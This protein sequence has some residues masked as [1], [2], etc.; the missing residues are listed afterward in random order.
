MSKLAIVLGELG[1]KT[2]YGAALS[3]A[4]L[5][6]EAT[7]FA[8]ANSN[9]DEVCNQM[10]DLISALS[11]EDDILEAARSTIS[12]MV[13]GDEEIKHYSEEWG[14]GAGELIVAFEVMLRI[15]AERKEAGEVCSFIAGQVERLNRGFRRH[16]KEAKLMKLWGHVFK[17]H[18]TRWG[19]NPTWRLGQEC[20]RNWE[21]RGWWLEEE[22]TGVRIMQFPYTLP[23]SAVTLQREL[24]LSYNLDY[25]DTWEILYP[26]QE[27]IIEDVRPRLI[28]DA[29]AYLEAYP[30]RNEVE[31][32]ALPKAELRVL[33]EVVES[34]RGKVARG[35]PNGDEAWRRLCLV[36]LVEVI[37]QILYRT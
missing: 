9:L 5:E 36:E 37:D 11:A 29:W 35:L 2:F 10:V 18:L 19:N 23:E 27:R 6:V 26:L 8:P 3:A 17:G 34:E 32:R 28:N 7:R 14:R 4:A 20:S 21:G 16:W 15:S 12:K 25:H 31:L 30:P 24:A 22:A 13:L 1:L 33:G